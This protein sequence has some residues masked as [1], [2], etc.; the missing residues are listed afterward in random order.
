MHLSLGQRLALGLYSLVLRIAFPVTLYHL[1]WRGMRQREY[2]LRWSERYALPTADRLRLDGCLWVHAVSVGEVLAARPLVDALLAR[3]PERPMLV[4]TITPTGSERVRAL[5][6]DRVHHQ[7]LPYDLAGMVRRFLDATKP[8]LAVIVETE[9]WLNLYVECGRRGIPLAMVNARLSERSL[10]GYLPVRWLAR[11]ALR[12]VRLVAAQSQ[13]DAAR[14]ARIGAEP[15]RIVTTGNLK[16]DL[17]LPEGLAARAAEWRAAWGESRPVWI[18]ASTHAPEEE[19]VLALREQV[20]ARFPE[21]LLLWAPRHPE[22]FGPVR[23]ALAER[24]LRVATRRSHGLPGAD[25]QVFVIDTIGELLG[26]FAAADVAFVGGSLCEV[27]GHNVLEPAALGVASVVGPH[28]FNFAEVTQ[29]LRDG[30]ALLQAADATALGEALVALLA[31]PARRRAMGDAG[32]A[33]V[34]EL[35][36]ALARTLEL[37]APMLE[38]NGERGTRNE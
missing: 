10:R 37:L 19:A 5:W 24:G 7:Y 17:R 20:A 8:A 28:T 13:A 27:G 14:L 33:Q 29:R 18:A 32:R 25:T 23:A 11:L 6:G 26:F 1:I 31:D 12:A 21:A 35:S 16:Y 22:R 9:I 36:G 3:Y 30:G 2:L 38:R 15:D 34:A 4:T